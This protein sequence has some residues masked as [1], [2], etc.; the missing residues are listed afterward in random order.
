MGFARQTSRIDTVSP[1]TLTAH[2]TVTE[3]D[4]TPP[5]AL[6]DDWAPSKYPVVRAYAEVSFAGGTNPSVDIGCYVRQLDTDN[7]QHVARA[8]NPDGRWESGTLRITGDDKIAFDILGE[9]DDF[10][11]LVEAVN[12]SPTAWSVT[13][14]VSP[15]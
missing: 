1:T 2:R 14:R 9:G 3:V 5:S 15:R 8:P 4:S 13:L 10:L 11:V 12:G 7:N 6:H